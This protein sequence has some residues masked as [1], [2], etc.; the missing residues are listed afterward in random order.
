MTYAR[1]HHL[2][3]KH[4]FGVG[5]SCRTLS[6]FK[7]K[8]TQ[9]DFSFEHNYT[10]IVSIKCCRQDFHQDCREECLSCRKA[11]PMCRKKIFTILDC[12]IRKKVTFRG[13]PV[14]VVVNPLPRGVAA[15]SDQDPPV[16]PADPHVPLA[17]CEA[18]DKL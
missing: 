12:F 6:E 9:D 13:P 3:N 14:D 18:S 8:P 5:K 1:T 2:H 4:I 15:N 7:E 16:V 10:N 11:R 17:P